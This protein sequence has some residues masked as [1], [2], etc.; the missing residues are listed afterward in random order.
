MYILPT[1]NDPD[2]NHSLQ[3]VATANEPLQDTYFGLHLT[4]ASPEQIAALE[5]YYAMKSE[6]YQTYLLGALDG[7]N[8]FVYIDGGSLTLV[9]AAQHDL[10]PNHDVPM[11]VPDDFLGLHIQGG[12]GRC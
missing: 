12:E 9:D 10:P 3:I 8:P 6:P 7:T 11:V 1:T 4:G 5:A 2:I